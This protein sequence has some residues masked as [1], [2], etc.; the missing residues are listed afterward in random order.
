MPTLGSATSTT[1]VSAFS[2]QPLKCSNELELPTMRRARGWFCPAKRPW[3]VLLTP[4]C[5]R[6][7]H[8]L[9]SQWEPLLIGMPPAHPASTGPRRMHFG[10]K[11]LNLPSLLQ[12]LTL[13]PG[14]V[15]AGLQVGPRPAFPAGIHP[16]L[17]PAPCWTP[18]GQS[19]FPGRK[20]S[21]LSWGQSSWSKQSSIPNRAKQRQSFP[22]ELELNHFES[23][24]TVG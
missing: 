9:V 22:C 17:C 11:P 16:I 18:P 14:Q 12:P 6:V 13:L 5:R 1:D 23:L 19:F 4:N 3:R 10:C 20:H 8:Q 15:S 7:F 2:K 21:V 24:S